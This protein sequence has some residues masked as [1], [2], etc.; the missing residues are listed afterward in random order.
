MRRN[1]DAYGAELLAAHH[2]RG[3]GTLE[4]VERDDGLINASALPVRYFSEYP[5][6]SGREKKAVRLV[7]GRV[8]DVGAGAGRFALHLQSRG[9]DITAIDNSPGAIKVCKLRGVSKALLRPILEVRR[10]PAGSFDTVIMMGNNFGLF[11]GYTRA[12][13]LLKDFFRI[14]SPDGR[15]IAEATD[16]YHTKD[17]LHLAYHRLNRRRGRMSGQL[18]LRVR[19]GNVIGDWFDYLL[20]SQKELKEIVAN[21]GWRIAEVISD[22]GSGYIVV[23]KKSGAGRP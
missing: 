11:G 1:K 14:T 21:T 16:P 17:V 7:K 23:L 10:F 9:H 12:K 6:W 22:Q 19:Y 18:R 3:H 5:A 15:I 2:S 8:L 4:I 20:V 13:R